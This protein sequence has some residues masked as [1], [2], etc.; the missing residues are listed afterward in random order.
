MTDAV[1]TAGETLSEGAPA[2]PVESVSADPPAATETKVETASEHPELKGVG[3][4]IDELTRNWREA[5]RREQ[6]LLQL[7]AKDRPE[8]TPPPPSDT[9][10][11]LAN[12]DYDEG[13]YQSYLFDEAVKRAEK[14]AESTISKKQ[15][16]ESV[17]RRRHEFVAREREFAKS[18]PDYYDVTRDQSLPFTDSFLETVSDSE[19]AAAVLYYLGKNPAL[20]NRLVDLSPNAASRE[21]GRIEGKLIAEREKAKSVAVSK[22][23]PPP[24]KIDAAGDPAVEKN[25]NEMTD[26]E[27][28][29]WRRK[30]ET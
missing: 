20:A 24:P 10:K 17:Q 30:Y 19:E 6:S 3:K 29:K 12:F 27:Y 23:P 18:I 26:R 28:A 13:K 9:P 15:D 14:A 11:T 5:E 8:P 16:L 25:P 1:T 22:A 21:I 7:L 4:R 2:L